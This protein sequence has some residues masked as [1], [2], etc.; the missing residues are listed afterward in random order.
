V[1][2]TLWFMFSLVLSAGLMAA[3]IQPA[4]AVTVGQVKEYIR[5]IEGRFSSSDHQFRIEYGGE[6]TIDSDGVASIPGL[7]I[8]ES[9]N[10]ELLSTQKIALVKILYSDEKLQRLEALTY[11]LAFE[12]AG[13]GIRFSKL[14]L[15]D[16]S[17]FEFLFEVNGDLPDEIKNRIF[18]GE[19]RFKRLAISQFGMIDGKGLEVRVAEIRMDKLENGVLD[20]AKLTDM[21]VRDSRVGNIDYM[22][23]ESVIAKKINIQDMSYIGGEVSYTALSGGEEFEVSG[24]TINVKGSSEEVTVE[25]VSLRGI[26]GVAGQIA[27]AKLEVSGV[28]VPV[29]TL[30]VQNPIA[31]VILAKLGQDRLKIDAE[32]A[33]RIDA[34]T[35]VLTVGPNWLKIDGLAAVHVDLQVVD[36]SVPALGR[37]LTDGEGNLSDMGVALKSASF[38]YEDDRL[39]N[40]MIE[41]SGGDKDV[42]VGLAEANM[43]QL[44]KADPEMAKNAGR[45]I[46]DFIFGANFLRIFVEADG[47]VGLKEIVENWQAGAI[48]KVLKVT[49]SGG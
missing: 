23:I 37:L 38:R 2:K 6:I 9:R 33:F 27:G 13:K 46:R 49:F 25:R 39:A 7:R 19:I 30:K 15:D 1:R 40:A 18:S 4:Q 31:P 5:G 20:A 12:N 16:A 32:F 11:E 8:S 34:E 48:S 41:M 17:S 36:L 3:A 14:V 21:S 10:G 35:G 47:L 42:L 44:F 26:E 29:E 45:A 22:N 24:A 43:W 28:V